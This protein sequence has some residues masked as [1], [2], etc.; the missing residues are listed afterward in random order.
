[1]E[2]LQD[3]NLTESL[4]QFSDAFSI[5]DINF[6]TKSVLYTSDI[7]SDFDHSYILFTNCYSLLMNIK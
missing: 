6:I 7:F 2:K 1:M 4:F 3:G 5:S